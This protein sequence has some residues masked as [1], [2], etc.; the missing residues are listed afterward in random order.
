[1]D[2]QVPLNQLRFGHED[3]EAI[4]AR[5]VGRNDDIAALAANLHARGQIENLI[6]KRNVDGGYSVSNGNRRLAAFHMIYGEGSDQLV[7][8]TV[9]DVDGAGAF[10]DSLTTAV[11]AKQLHPVDQYEAFA[12]L[13]ESGKENEEIARQYGLTDKDVQRALALG[14]L[15]P[16]V[17]DAWRH[18]EI[19]A[20]VAQA[21]T[22]AAT[23]KAQDK[24]FDK[25]AKQNGLHAHVIRRE[26]G[27]TDSEVGQLLPFVGADAYR[28][29]GGT[30]TVDLFGDAHIVSDPALLKQLASD[31]LQEVCDNLKA[32]GWAWAKSMSDLPTG[33]RW[34]KK[35]EPK[36]LQFEGDEEQR[37]KALQSERKAL[38]DRYQSDEEFDYDEYEEGMERLDRDIESLEGLVRARSF[39]DRQ[40]A[41]AGCI[42]DI[43]EGALIVTY[44]VREPEEVKSAGGDAGES[45]KKKAV[46]KAAKNDPPDDVADAE[47]SNALVHRL[48]VQLTTGT[49]TALAQDHELALCVLLAG[50]A[51]DHGC[52]VRLSVIGL[53]GSTLDL[54]G[55]CNFVDALTLARKLKHEERL[56]L[57]AEIAAA[58]L[59]F[60]NKPLDQN[61]TDRLH[62]PRSVCAAIDAVLLNPALRGAF[63]ARD[64]FGAVPK[65]IALAAI[66][67]ALGPDAAKPLANKPKADIVDFAIANVPG[68]GWLPPQLRAAGY[69]GPPI[70]KT[71]KLPPACKAAAK[72]KA[73]P[74]KRGKAAPLKKRAPAKKAAKKAAKKRK[75]A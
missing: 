4:N 6:V 56:A 52:G 21:F 49:A 65:A 47:I 53:G 40:K 36:A 5:V 46:N 23:H 14:H 1:M 13:A 9:R 30:V 16:Q 19:K 35:V 10:E 18:G 54:F 17:R 31:R 50:F 60:Q 20:E 25:L 48:S 2:I 44:G 57:V 26:L 42:V 8:C 12:R 28:A 61:P 73:A 29:A 69:D 66:A 70:G 74:T 75:A 67:D 3:Q 34:W 72:K 32:E 39:T 45:G 22:L 33:A 27:A 64:Y 15:S 38:E 68:T 62:G 43:D 51:A 59:D 58:A 41:A 11:T 24:L 37:L 63:D 55:T 71:V 7:N